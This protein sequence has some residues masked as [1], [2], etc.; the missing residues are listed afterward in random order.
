MTKKQSVTMPEV[1]RRL[2][3]VEHGLAAVEA[4]IDAQHDRLSRQIN[5][6][7]DRLDATLAQGIEHAANHHG[8]ATMVRQGSLTAAAAALLAIIA[9]ILL[10]FVG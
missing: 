1:E 10:R 6:V 8:R 2:T 7:S 3:T 5:G 4:R 9:Q